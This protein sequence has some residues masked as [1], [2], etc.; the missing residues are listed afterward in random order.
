MEHPS[1]DNTLL[2]QLTI[3]EVLHKASASIREYLC[4]KAYLD[5]Q[6]G[7]QE[8]FQQFHQGKPTPLDALPAYA[9]FTEKVAYDHK[10]AQYEAELERWKSTMQH[11]TKAVKQLLFNVLLFPDG[12]WLIDANN[13]TPRDPL[14]KHQLDKLRNLCIPKVTLLLLTVMSEMNE[15]SACIELAD[16]IASEQYKLYTV[17]SKDA[18]REIY[19]KICESSVVL[20]DQKK[21]AWGYPK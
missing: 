18:M 17:F 15:H 19:K 8:W 5:A 2:E 10:K 14:R 3:N 20:M 21:D 11:H 16:V 7:F 1:L 6:E 13:L 9:T 12:G 4:Y